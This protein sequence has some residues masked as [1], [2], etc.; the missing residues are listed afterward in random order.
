MHSDPDAQRFLVCEDTAEY[1]RFYVLE[2]DESRARN[3]AGNSLSVT[4]YTTAGTDQTTAQQGRGRRGL[5]VEQTE[6]SALRNVVH[7]NSIN[8]FGCQSCN[9][10]QLQ[11]SQQQELATSNKQGKGSVRGN[12]ALG[13]DASITAPHQRRAKER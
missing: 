8:P 11:Q 10:M 1:Q 13:E 6:I 7:F 3:G 12:P 4:V 2:Y 5:E 9:P